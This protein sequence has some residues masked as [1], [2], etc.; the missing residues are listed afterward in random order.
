[1]KIK[2][3]IILFLSTITSGYTQITQIQGVVTDSLNG[4][5]IPY[6]KIKIINSTFG[7]L[8][9]TSGS[10]S[11]LS[12]PES[13]S[14]EFSF[15]GYKPQ[16][17]QFTIGIPN[18]IN[19]IL[20]PDIKSFDVVEVIAG[21]NPAFEILRQV[22]KHKKQNNPE[23][24]DAYQCEV[25]NLMQFDANKLG[26]KFE[27]RKAFNKMKVI[28]DYVGQD[29]VIDSKYLPV[30]LTE[31]ISDYYFKK[32]PVQRKEIIKANRITGVDYLQLQQFTGDMHQNVNIYNNYI[33]LFNKEFMSPIAD[34]GKVFYKYYLQ[35]EDTIDGVFCYHMVFVPKRKGDAVFEGEMW[36]VD[37]S[38]AIKKVIAKIPN[39]VN[40]NYVSDLYVEQTYSEVDSGIWMVTSENMLAYFDLFNDF[41]KKNMMG[42]TIHK[43]TSRRNFVLNQPKEYT[44]YSADIVLSDS[45]ANRND[46]YWIENRHN[47]LSHEEKGVIEMVDSLKNNRRF[48][49]YEKLTYFAYSGFWK[50]GP[51][52]IGNIY[53]VY[54]KNTVEGD[55][56][57]LSLRTSNKFSTKVEINAF[58]IYGFGD[59]V[60]KYGASLRWKV[61]NDPREMLRFAY[62]KRIEQ[63]GLS[64]SIG[65]IGNSFTTLFSLGPLD[66]LTMVEKASISFEKDWKI[67]MRTF[68]A[69]DWRRFVP[70]GTSDYSR[71]DP[72]TGDTNQISRLTSFEI[73]N[74]IIYTKDEK[75]LKGQFDRISLGSKY[76]IL[77]LTHTWGISD[78]IGSEY[79]FHRLDFVY[80]HRPRVGMFGRLQYSIYA[81]KI[82][83]TVPYPFLNIHQGNQ[84]FYLQKTTF[85]LM[86]YYEFI[87]DEWVGVNFEHRFQGFIMDKIPLIKKLK[88]R[89]VYNAKMVIGRYNNKHNSEL[90]LPTY[91]N[92][93]QYPY[94]EVGVGL[95]NIFKFIRLDA[96]WRLS[97]R[98]NVDTNGDQ[99]RNFGVLFTF[100][101]DF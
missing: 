72:V 74:Q 71:V 84:T 57:M 1:M 76:P 26:K 47:P 64:S 90:L 58:G 59:K 9:D 24:L 33:E 93:L 37:T 65:D 60:V 18:N 49:F 67:D 91:S 85:N 96:V 88:W 21:E 14:V 62:R 99:V 16:R 5:P 78:V 80:D 7:T 101:T 31:S 51:I 34:G 98:D 20:A 43:K 54:N 56:F 83:G 25:Y 28:N 100:T 32:G 61:K 81:G 40:L 94:Y 8:S 35:E 95:E 11:F 17:I 10:Y 4:E 82:F 6:V 50:A 36:I 46:E 55:R 52:E 66:K 53:S 73:R 19:V 45:A 15:I 63:L 2:L 68:H 44:F 27:E 42:A 79:N 13:D 30:L 70:L 77:S 23:K 69:A 12:K 86:R 3:V 48:K 39:N 97:Y 87:S 29:S 22:K 89:L 38:F 92:R 41:K 75:F